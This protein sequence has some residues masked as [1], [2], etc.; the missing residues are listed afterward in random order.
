MNLLL[1]SI[2]FWS[3]NWPEDSSGKSTKF[4]ELFNNLSKVKFPDIK[5]I[6]P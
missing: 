6:H 5:M 4:K 3:T 2:K 1:N